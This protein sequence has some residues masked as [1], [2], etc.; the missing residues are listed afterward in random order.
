MGQLA[1]AGGIDPSMWAGLGG[2]TGRGRAVAA[3]V[4]ARRRQESKKKR[5][6]AKKARKKG[7]K[8]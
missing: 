2:A 8:R 4:E 5:K 6:D 3:S 7:R 1:G